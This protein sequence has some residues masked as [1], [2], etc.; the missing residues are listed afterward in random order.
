MGTLKIGLSKKVITPPAK[1]CAIFGIDYYR[2]SQYVESDLYANAVVLEEDDT[3]IMCSCDIT[4]ITDEF[5]AIVLE[6][7]RK[8][9]PEINTDKISISATHTHNSPYPNET[10][11]Q[12]TILA[13]YLPE[14]YTYEDDTPYDPEVWLGDRTVPYL[15]EK[16]AETICQA[17]Q[18]R[19]EGYYSPGFGRCVVGFTRRTQYRDGKVINYG[20]TNSVNFDCMQ[21]VN[22]TGVEMLFLFDENKKPIGAI[23]NVACPAQVLEQVHI[24]GADYWG[25][26]RDFLK[27][28]FGEDFVLVGLCGAAGDMTPRDLVRLPRYNSLVEPML[29]IIPRRTD[30]E[31]YTMESLM[32]VSERLSMEIRRVYRKV[33]ENLSDS[34][35]IVCRRFTMSFPGKIIDNETYKEAKKTVREY[36]AKL[37]NKALSSSEMGGILLPLEQIQR[38]K[39]QEFKRMKKSEIF[40]MRFADMAFAAFPY[41]LFVDY[42]NRI[43]AR[44]HATQTFLIQLAN[45]SHG[46]LPTKI[47]YGSGGYGVDR[48]CFVEQSAGELLTETI[49]AEIMD[50]M[51]D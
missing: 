9:A 25:K 8:M 31:V 2:P 29:D 17:W 45:G 16:I 40:I 6:H 21:G 11:N 3:I 24:I 5:K 50:I 20:V 44:S 32:D 26:C 23:V 49:I 12:F 42:G 47:A 19:K 7:V 35:K 14:G 22:D 41:E 37:E 39:E 1:S 28:D 15:A 51:K 46:Y 33:C 18:K 48:V 34:A 38:Y 10:V 13:E 4:Q 27:E 36:V 30:P 43:K